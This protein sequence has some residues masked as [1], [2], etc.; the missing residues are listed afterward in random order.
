MKKDKTK[1]K[2]EKKILGVPANLDF[3]QKIKNISL[4]HKK[5][6]ITN[7][8]WLVILNIALI[9]TMI[10]YLI[11]AYNPWIL[12]IALFTVIVCMVWSILTYFLNI[13]KIKYTIYKHA[14]VKDYDS[15]KNVGEFSKLVGIKIKQT[16]LDRIGKENTN[17]LVLQ[18]SNKWDSKITFH[19]ITENI[20]DL[21]NLITELSKEARENSTINKVVEKSLITTMLENSPSQSKLTH[22]KKNK[23]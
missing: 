22:K 2:K 13:V 21:A 4:N 19:C 9:G 7:L 1:S 18:F 10:Y 14:I 17:T 23:K 3:G 16:F 8:I 11:Q 6:R 12:V 15:S 5:I 20:N